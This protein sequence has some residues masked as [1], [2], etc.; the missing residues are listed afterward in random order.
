MKQLLEFSYWFE[1]WPGNLNLPFWRAVIVGAGGELVIAV[2]ASVMMRRAK[3]P[4]AKKV[5]RRFGT[6]GYTTGIISLLLAFF[7]FQNAYFL[8]MRFFIFAWLAATL[9]WL[10]IIVKFII[11][12]MPRRRKAMAD[13]AEFSKYLPTKKS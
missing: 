3:D 4:L 8:S 7:R 6:W 11:R 10:L 5:W 9:V 1:L 2:V 12:D 13:R